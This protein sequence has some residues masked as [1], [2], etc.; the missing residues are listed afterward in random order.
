MSRIQE[1]DIDLPFIDGIY[2]YAQ[3]F[4]GDTAAIAAHFYDEEIIIG[5]LELATQGELPMTQLERVRTRIRYIAGNVMH[6]LTK[7]LD[8]SVLTTVKPDLGHERARTVANKYCTE[9]IV[10]T[11][12]L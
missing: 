10:N 11:T 1:L 9:R 12:V 7:P 4:N 5:A 3:E 6:V 2:P 8:G